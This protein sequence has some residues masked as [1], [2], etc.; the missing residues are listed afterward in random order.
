MSSI[1]SRSDSFCQKFGLKVP[2][3]L[4]PMAGASAPALSI[5]V[6]QAGGLGACGALPLSPSEIVSW[7]NAVRDGCAGPFQINLWIPDPLPIRDH[8]AEA[9]MRDF[10]ADWGPVVDKTAGDSVPHNS[11]GSGRQE[12]G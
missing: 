4:A 12:A 11:H 2:I 7:A 1:T 5:A 3:L 9:L 6:M 10:L 8:S